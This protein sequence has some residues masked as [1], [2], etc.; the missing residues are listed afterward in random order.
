[1]NWLGSVLRV[2]MV[3]ACTATMVGTAATPQLRIMP[4]GDSI[5]SGCCV[6]FEGGYRTRLFNLLVNAGYAVDFVGTQTTFSNNGSLGDPD[7]EGHGGTE[8]D[9]IYLGITGWLGTVE[10][11]DI[12]LLQ[13][14]TNDFAGNN[15]V[16]NAKWRLERLIERI[17]TLRPHAKILVGNLLPRTDLIIADFQIQNL[18][19]PYIPGIVAR[20]AGLGRNIGFVD[21]RDGFTT[22]DLSDG[23]HP[24]LAGYNKIADRW[25]S[26]IT[27]V[28]GPNGSVGAPEIS[29]VRGQIDLR[30]V[31]VTFSKPVSDAAAN[32][33]NFTIGGGVS[34]L[35]AQLD[36]ETRRVITL[37]TTPQMVSTRYTLMVNNIRDRTPAENVIAANTSVY[38]Q[39]ANVAEAVDYQ[40]VYSL[41]IPN[42][43]DFNS[44]GVPYTVDNHASIGSFSRVAYYL[45]LQTREG[46]TRY[47]WVSMDAF[48][49][50]AAKLGVPTAQ[51]GAFF[52][53]P[54]RNVNLRSSNILPAT[55]LTGFLEF[56]GSDYY[57]ANALNVSNGSGSQYDWGD[58]A[59]PGAAGYGSMQVHNPAG[60]QTLIAFNG[61]GGAGLIND[62][63]IGNS[64]GQHPDWTSAQNADEFGG[65]LLQVYVLPGGA[66]A[67][68]PVIAQ[69][70]SDATAAIGGSATLSV[71]VSGVGPFVYQWRHDGSPIPGANSA[72]LALNNVQP[73]NAGSYYVVVSNASG[74]APSSPA[75]L[76]VLS[77][78]MLPNG[79]FEAGYDGWMALGNQLIPQAAGI[80]R[81]SHGSRVVVFNIGDG[82]PNGVL[83]HAFPTTAG[84]TY[85]LAFDA[86]VIAFN[87]NEQRLHVTVQGT[88]LL[89]DRTVTMSGTGNGTIGWYPQTFTFTADSSSTTVMFQD[90]STQTSAI[91]LL[92]DNVRVSRQEPIG[93]TL[94]VTSSNPGS[95]VLMR[96]APKDQ[97]GTGA[98]VTGITRTYAP[99]TLITV[100]A[101]TMFSGNTFSKWQ[102]NGVDFS[103]NPRVSFRMDED[104]HLHALYV[105][106]RTLTVNS[107]G[108]S[109]V[110]IRL[111]PADNHGAGNGAAGFTRQYPSGAQVVLAAPPSVGGVQFKRWLHN[112][113]EFSSNPRVSLT[114]SDNCTLTAVY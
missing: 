99:G 52:Q 100:S 15:D 14:G 55:G 4:L 33:S 26:A 87:L 25:F 2:L 54:V 72:T 56:W 71:V 5:T 48:T 73:G 51:S 45:E 58:S 109:A 30:H 69:H 29:H 36:S 16:T 23:L 105:A 80:Y 10:D 82:A 49:T 19:N 86:G 44:S 27:A 53:Q 103:F 94:S 37:T 78:E 75:V 79:S 107:T 77:D 67:S 11:P 63:G 3:L 104:V 41:N 96:I 101:A 6:D 38:F 46:G 74:S 17:A 85:T 31:T 22:A 13:I 83:L 62:V 39:S 61:W 65:K 108:A 40:L 89:L 70:P 59:A 84:Q 34:V 92:L 76:T 9:A 98:G 113:T 102:K 24:N 35:H 110:P 114:L 93:R 21:I 18:Y 68:P 43:A 1:M 97:N 95:G 28:A 32:V 57:P 91:D 12:I 111:G 88:R 8:I 106:T 20:Q 81:A 42:R 64:A 60:R 112:G 50:D 7:H 90:V 47:A 66:V